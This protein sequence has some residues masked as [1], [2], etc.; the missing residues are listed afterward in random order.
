MTSRTDRPNSA[1]IPTPN[2]DPS[3]SLSWRFTPARP[4]LFASRPRWPAAADAGRCRSPAR[5][6]PAEFPFPIRIVERLVRE[7]QRDG[8][9]RP[10]PVRLLAALVFGCSIQPIQTVLEA[11]PGTIDLHPNTNRGLVADAAWA[12]I[13]AR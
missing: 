1:P 11:P 4:G 6:L 13:R 3:R 5:A 7:G 2:G 9:V 10:G 8:S 12:S